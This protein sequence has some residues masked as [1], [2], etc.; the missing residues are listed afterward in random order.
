VREHEAIPF[1]GGTPVPV[2]WA[3]ARSSAAI[4]VLARCVTRLQ[5]GVQA[6][7]AIYA[8]VCGRDRI[9]EPVTSG[10]KLGSKHV[11]SDQIV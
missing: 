8:N 5:S 3:T 1:E 2:T 7:L 11:G 9:R 10:D 4:G 6:E